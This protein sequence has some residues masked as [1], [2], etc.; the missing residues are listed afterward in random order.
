VT[1]NTIQRDEEKEAPPKPRR[2]RSLAKTHTAKTASEVQDEVIRCYARSCAAREFA[3]AEFGRANVWVRANTD[4]DHGPIV[5]GE[6]LQVDLPTLVDT[7]LLIQ[8]NS[9]GGKSGARR[10]AVLGEASKALPRA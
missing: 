5:G 9:G 4:N 1:P 6:Q 8:A 3:Q 10:A 2:D 7:R